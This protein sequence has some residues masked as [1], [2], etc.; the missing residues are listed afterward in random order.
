MKR[1]KYPQLDF[2]TKDDFK[3]FFKIL[4][5]RDLEK[6]VKF[7]NADARSVAKKI[8]NA[9]SPSEWL[10][11]LRAR[12]NSKLVLDALMAGTCSKYIVDNFQN[13]LLGY[14]E[15]PTLVP[16]KGYFPDKVQ[17]A[18]KLIQLSQNYSV[19][20]TEKLRDWASAV[21]NHAHHAAHVAYRVW[22]IENVSQRK[23]EFNVHV[24]EILM[25]AY[26]KHFT[27]YQTLGFFE[28]H[29]DKLPLNKTRDLAK[30][31]FC[32][33]NEE[34]IFEGLMGAALGFHDVI[35]AIVKL[36]LRRVFPEH[37]AIIL[38]AKL[39]ENYD[40]NKPIYHQAESFESMLILLAA[41]AQRN[42]VCQHSSSDIVHYM[43]SDK[44]GRAVKAL[45][46]AGHEIDVTPMDYERPLFHAI[47][48]R[49]F[50]AA[51]AILNAGG[52]TQ[53][54]YGW[55]V[56]SPMRRAC[57]LNYEDNSKSLIGLLLA[58]GAELKFN[59]FF[60]LITSVRCDS[61]F[62]P[63][64]L[65]NFGQAFF[66]KELFEKIPEII[67]LV[68]KYSH[69]QMKREE[70]YFF[71]SLLELVIYFGF[72]TVLDHFVSAKVKID[73]AQLNKLLFTGIKHNSVSFVQKLNQLGAD[74]NAID[75]NGRTI[76]MNAALIDSDNIVLWGV[77][78]N[79]DL[80]CKDK[81]GDSS[82]N[83]AEEYTKRTGLFRNFSKC[84]RMLSICA[85]LDGATV[86]F[87]DALAILRK[88]EFFP[89]DKR[90]V[91][92]LAKRLILR[93]Q[94]GE[95]QV[96]DG[97]NKIEEIFAHLEQLELTLLTTGSFTSQFDAAKQQVMTTHAQN[98]DLLKS[99]Q[100]V[101]TTGFY[102]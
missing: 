72:E 93:H 92:A 95:P 89:Y 38:T 8:L 101:V 83:L 27:E 67:Q 65:V 62:T 74:L 94:A 87:Q 11:I 82:L 24:F 51:E 53:F 86:S 37:E 77:S 88:Q 10:D 23:E 5:V 3:Y 14:I 40:S 20:N 90:T 1:I 25:L 58:H 22:L 19:A 54:R 64:E 46:A 49:A 12:T 16:E 50:D 52:L 75:D 56:V 43:H 29:A 30:I 60:T 9:R 80:S 68:Q 39:P 102:M 66:P 59:D 99:Q 55:Y 18:K 47:E 70:H 28:K 13:G 34:E 41:G 17:E 69:S 61:Q 98:A 45:I 4:P 79:I 44:S 35:S 81:N 31:Y 6:W 97:L 96:I 78:S 100:D 32:K 21:E 42:R 73:E 36:R 84:W 2:V 63:A 85:Q 76:F 71:D 15:D 26:R 48:L 57:L 33:K 7:E 91:S